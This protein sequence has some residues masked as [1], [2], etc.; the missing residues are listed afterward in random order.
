MQC[1]RRCIE[2]VGLETHLKSFHSGNLS[3][4]IGDP[5]K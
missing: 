2:G 5:V 4:V 3:Y 1:D